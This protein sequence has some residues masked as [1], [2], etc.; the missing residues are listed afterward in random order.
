MIGNVG[1]GAG[2]AFAGIAAS[3]SASFAWVL[4]FLVVALIGFGLRIE[5]L[6][7]ERR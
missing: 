4:I 5:A 3:T 2:I 1:I 6:L 7:Q